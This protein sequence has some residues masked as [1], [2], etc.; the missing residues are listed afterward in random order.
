MVSTFISWPMRGVIA[1]SLLLSHR[2]KPVGNQLRI[3]RNDRSRINPLLDLRA[4][5][6]SKVQ[7]LYFW[8]AAFAG[9]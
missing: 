9:G 6:E 1:W 8:Q 3:D 4:P 2:L 7:S 5:S